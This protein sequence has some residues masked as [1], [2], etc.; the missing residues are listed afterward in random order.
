MKLQYNNVDTA[1]H[2][3]GPHIQDVSILLRSCEIQLRIATHQGKHRNVQ[4]FNLQ[5]KTSVR[6]LTKILKNSYQKE[7]CIASCHL[8]KESNK[9]M[10]QNTLSAHRQLSYTDQWS[11]RRNNI[12]FFFT[13]FEK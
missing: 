10:Q 5:T 12:M 2:L 8:I 3:N 11:S 7:S 4:S 6:V 13:W 1:I 9:S